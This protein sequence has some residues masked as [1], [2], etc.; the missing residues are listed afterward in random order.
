MGQADFGSCTADDT[1]CLCHNEA[2]VA[3][4]TDCINTTCSDADREAA[5]LGAQ[6][7]CA[8]VVSRPFYFFRFCIS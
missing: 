7:L 6:Q 5:F 1:S 2:F 4:V 8:A 3:S